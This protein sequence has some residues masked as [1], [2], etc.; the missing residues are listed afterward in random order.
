MRGACKSK[1]RN[2]KARGQPRAQ[3]QKGVLEQSISYAKTETKPREERKGEKTTQ[4]S[5]DSRNVHRK[6]ERERERKRVKRREKREETWES[7]E[8]ERIKREARIRRGEGGKRELENREGFNCNKST[9][10]VILDGEV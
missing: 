2:I 10:S 9:V 8:C 1:T 7:Q 5:E 3:E 4:K 6:K